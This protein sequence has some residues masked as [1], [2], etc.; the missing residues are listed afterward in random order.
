M[1]EDEIIKT[2]INS[3]SEEPE[4]TLRDQVVKSRIGRGI[5]KQRLRALEE[6]CKLCGIDN[7]DFLRASHPKHWRVSNNKERLDQYNGFLLCPAHDFLFDKG[8]ISF[9]DDG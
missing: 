7:P 6:K 4:E 5:F 8:L 1:T 2:E 3:V 9:C